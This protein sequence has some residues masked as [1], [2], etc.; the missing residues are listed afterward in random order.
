MFICSSIS[1]EL[2]QDTN[3]N[4]CAKVCD[5]PSFWQARK[6]CINSVLLYQENSSCNLIAL[7]V[8]EGFDKL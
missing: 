5:K 6:L 7:Q 1:Y 4:V 2:R 3:K 8:G